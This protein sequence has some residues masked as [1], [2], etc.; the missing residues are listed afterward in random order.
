[1]T[2]S[3]PSK[4]DAQANLASATAAAPR[5]IYGHRNGGEYVLFAHSLDEE[6]LEPLVHYYSLDKKT[7]WTRTLKVWIEVVDS[8]LR[9]WWVR[10]ASGSEFL[11]AVDHEETFINSDIR[12][13]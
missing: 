6:T 8:R 9:F 4:N 1:M 2:S 11:Q 12:D 7:R 5:G 13:C 10:A 3:A